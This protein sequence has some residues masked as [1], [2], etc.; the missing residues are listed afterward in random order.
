MLAAELTDPL[1]TFLDEEEG[2]S[3]LAR[4]CEWASAH[5]VDIAALLDWVHRY[6]AARER[7]ARVEVRLRAALGLPLVAGPVCRP[8]PE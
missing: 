1:S 3:V 7:K 5:P 2:E 4:A 8:L 6:P